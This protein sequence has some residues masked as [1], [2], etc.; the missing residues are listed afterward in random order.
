MNQRTLKLSFR[1]K[2]GAPGTVKVYVTVRLGQERGPKQLHLAYLPATQGLSA[3]DKLLL[4]QRLRQKWRRQ[5]G[6]AD[7]AIDWAATETKWRQR[8]QPK[9]APVNRDVARKQLRQWQSGAKE[10]LLPQFGGPKRQTSEMAGGE[11]HVLFM[12]SHLGIVDRLRH[13][14]G[15][16]DPAVVATWWEEQEA[17]CLLCCYHRFATRRPGTKFGR[18]GYLRYLAGNI[19]RGLAVAQFL[20]EHPSPPHSPRSLTAQGIEELRARLC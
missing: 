5:F 12:E 18:A 17:P 10:K 7:V 1:R 9:Q 16:V 20:R 3:S 13:S 14:G 19:A 15:S 6:P 8:D 4:E 2:P 11:F